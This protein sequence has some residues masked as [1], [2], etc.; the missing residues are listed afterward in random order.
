MIFLIY[1][2][3]VFLVNKEEG[4]PSNFLGGTLFVMSMLNLCVDFRSRRSLSAGGSGSLLGAITPAV[5]PLP[6][7]PSGVERLPLQST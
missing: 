2:A 4:V 7:T 5:S 3:N 1:I 6:R